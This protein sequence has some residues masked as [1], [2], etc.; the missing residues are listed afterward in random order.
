MSGDFLSLAADTAESW[1]VAGTDGV[2]PAGRQEHR[3]PGLG[4]DPVKAA[5]HCALGQGLFKIRFPHPG[6]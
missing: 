1:R 4:L 6:F 3:R 2:D 5:R